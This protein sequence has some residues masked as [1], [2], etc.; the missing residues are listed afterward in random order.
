MKESKAMEILGEKIKGEVMALWMVTKVT[1]IGTDV[2]DILLKGMA[3]QHWFIHLPINSTNIY[4]VPIMCQTLRKALK[5]HGW[6]R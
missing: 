2:Y 3:K 1:H 4:Q 5:R 6:K